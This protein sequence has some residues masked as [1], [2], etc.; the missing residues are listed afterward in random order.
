MIFSFTKLVKDVFTTLYILPSQLMPLSWRA[1][2]CLDV[3]EAK[4]YLKIDANVVKCCYSLKI[5]SG[6]HGF[7]NKKKDEPLILNIDV[8]ND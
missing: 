3:I 4:C 8:V 7:V 2:A 5:F 1:L 6:C